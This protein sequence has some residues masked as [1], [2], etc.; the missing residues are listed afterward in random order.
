MAK[1]ARLEDLEDHIR[2]KHKVDFPLIQY[3]DD[4]KDLITIDTE[5]SF[6]KALK[7]A[8][9]RSIDQRLPQCV[10]EVFIDEKKGYVYKCKN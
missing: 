3:E 2:F 6:E 1:D 4:R 5:F 10:L 8:D 7:I 9:E